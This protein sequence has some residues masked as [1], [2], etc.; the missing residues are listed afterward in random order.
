L[1]YYCQQRP[2][3]CPRPK[4]VLPDQGNKP[5]VNNFYFDRYNLNEQLFPY[6]TIL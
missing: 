1:S 4:E 5:L 6:Q 3:S 2:K